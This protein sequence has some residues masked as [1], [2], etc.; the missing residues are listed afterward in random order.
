MLH[1]KFQRGQALSEYMVL[2]PAAIMIAIG[3]GFISGFIIKSLNQTV[4]AFEPYGVEVCE[5]NRPEREG[6]TF[7]E[8]GDHSVEL[9]S[10]VYNEADDTTTVTYT[11][12]SG[13]QPSISHWTL[14]LPQ[15]VADHIV[16]SSEAY[17]SWGAD[18]TTGIDG[19]KFDTPYNVPG[20]GKGQGGKG[21]LLSPVRRDSYQ[22]SEE[23]INTISRDVILM[24]EGQ[25]DFGSALTTV[26]AGTEVH[27][28]TI[29]APIRVYDPSMNT[30]CEQ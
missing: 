29:S 12:T 23:E 13:D 25:W 28:I 20:G 2:I 22:P 26:K 19:I 24:V 1:N 14:G 15:S 21:K 30:E 7:V 6:P 10:L 4:D 17:Q 8:A 16:D 5:T 11:I 18:P 27:T 3:A 9:T